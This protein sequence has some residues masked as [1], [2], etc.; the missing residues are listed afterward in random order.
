[1]KCSF[2]GKNVTEESLHLPP[3]VYS[4]DLSNNNLS[5]VPVSLIG[6]YRNIT[7]LTL[8]GNSLCNLTSEGLLTDFSLLQYLSLQRNSIR[9]VD[10]K[11]FRGLSRLKY[12]NL[13]LNNIKSWTGNQSQGTHELE[14][15]DITGTI[16]WVPDENILALPRLKELRGVT[17]C[18]FCPNCTVV[19][20][21]I[22]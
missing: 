4:L 2:D 21:Q 9:D 13:S 5:Y 1:V 7:N 11:F 12:L 14:Y 6:K 18:K 17:W 19:N 22:L 3:D 8:D 15:L 10:S 16:D 20:P